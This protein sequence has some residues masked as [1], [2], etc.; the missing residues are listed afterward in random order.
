MPEGAEFPRSAAP[1]P[2]D[3]YI[4]HSIFPRGAAVLTLALQLQSRLF[5]FTHI[6][7]SLPRGSPGPRY[8]CQRG[9]GE[10]RLNLYM[11]LNPTQPQSPA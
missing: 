7:I 5:C 6:S 3:R 2:T 4:R 8:G 11:A 1:L 9:G 10:L